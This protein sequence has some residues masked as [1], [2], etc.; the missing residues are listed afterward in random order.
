VVG[1][2]VSTAIAAANSGSD[3]R[4]LDT[5]RLPSFRCDERRPSPVSLGDE[6]LRS[7][8]R[9]DEQRT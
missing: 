8:W 9:L 3:G 2:K 7:E 1:G 4:A 5:D 6:P